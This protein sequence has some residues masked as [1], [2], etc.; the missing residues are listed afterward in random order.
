[1]SEEKT[2]PVC[3]SNYNQSTR[4][5]VVCPYNTENKDEKGEPKPCRYECCKE[6]IRA[7]ITHSNVE[8]CCMQ[9]NTLYGRDFMIENLSR[10]WTDGVYKKK[11]EVILGER[12]ISRCVDVMVLAENYMQIPHL[13]GRLRQVNQSLMRLLT[14]RRE[15]EKTLKCYKTYVLPEDQKAKKKYIQKCFKSGCMG[16]LDQKWSC[17]L[18]NTVTCRHCREIMEPDEFKDHVCKEEDKKNIAMITKD[19]KS[20]PGCGEMIHKIDGCDQMWCVECKTAW[21][22]KSGEVEKGR[23]H[24]PHYYAYLRTQNNPAN[25]ERKRGEFPHAQ[26]WATFV[27]KSRIPNHSIPSSHCPLYSVL[28]SLH[29]YALHLQHYTI[30]SMQRKIEHLEEVSKVNR[31]MF[32]AKKYTKENLVKQTMQD[33]TVKTMEM[34]VLNTFSFFNRVLREKITEIYDNNPDG[35]CVMTNAQ[36]VATKKVLEEIERV[37]MTVNIEL[38]RISYRYKKTVKKIGKLRS[39]RT[40]SHYEYEDMW[41]RVTSKKTLEEHIAKYSQPINIW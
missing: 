10:N 16:F 7:Y 9:C 22:W 12:E 19:T 35:T 41:V 14:Q 18:C 26:F 33:H 29:R 8:A 39:Q 17:G 15:L 5:K 13:E 21:S 4:K 23:I 25:H 36:V 28:M 24:N 38:A 40:T 34:E 6:C 31:I 3:C 27:C 20:C 1:M 11:L 2:C 32:L 30:R 37:R